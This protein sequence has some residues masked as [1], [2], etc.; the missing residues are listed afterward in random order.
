MVLNNEDSAKKSN[1]DDFFDISLF[2]ISKDML[3]SCF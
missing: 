1:Q 2:F 3:S